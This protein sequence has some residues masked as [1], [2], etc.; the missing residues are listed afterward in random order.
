MLLWN[1]NTGERERKNPAT[2]QFFIVSH[3]IVFFIRSNENI[4]LTI[5]VIISTTSNLCCLRSIN[6]E[7]QPTDTLVNKDRL[8]VRWQQFRLSIN[9]FQNTR[10]S[11]KWQ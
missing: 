8:Y 9:I 4:V 2:A 5:N 11:F 3:L 10:E 6:M 7:D 1:T